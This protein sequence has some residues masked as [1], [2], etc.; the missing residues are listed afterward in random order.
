MKQNMYGFGLGATIVGLVFIC[1]PAIVFSGVADEAFA[2]SRMSSSMKSDI[3]SLGD[4]KIYKLPIPV[5]GVKMSELR[6]TWGDARAAGR[7][8]EG[9]DIF[10]DRGTAVISPT[11]AVIGSIGYGAT[12]GNFIFTI[13]PGQERY[14]FAHLDGIR[15]GLSRGDVVS[16]GEVIGYVGNTGNADHANPHLHFGIYSPRT[17]NPFSRLTHVYD[18]TTTIVKATSSVAITSVKA[19]APIVIAIDVPTV[20]LE[21][22]DENE[23]VKKLQLFLINNS[24]GVN[25]NRLAGAGSTGYFGQITKNA[26]AEYQTNNNIAPA[27]GYY[28]RIT[29]YQINKSSLTTSLTRDLEK[30]MKGDDV[31]ALQKYLNTMGY[32]VTSEGSGSPGNETIYFGKATKAALIA[33]QKAHGISPSLGY[34]GPLTRAYI[35][36]N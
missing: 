2:S 4:A 24:E 32:R 9:V 26:L 28:G 13:N 30:G 27:S 14:Y 5:Q 12:G 35:K 21:E 17:I 29:R 15:E 1:F 7:S 23:D 36:N 19:P 11:N 25:R 8:H 34:F 3:S 33:F 22:G 16:A 31:L 18:G 10:A 6:D 20:D